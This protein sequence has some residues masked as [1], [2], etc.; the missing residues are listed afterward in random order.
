MKR[1]AMR[2][3]S[4]GES[5]LTRRRETEENRSPRSYVGALGVE[6]DEEIVG[7]L[8]VFVLFVHRGGVGG[9]SFGD[10]GA[11]ADADDQGAPAD[12]DQ[13]RCGGLEGHGVPAG[14]LI[15]CDLG[16]DNQ[17]GQGVGPA[18]VPCHSD[19]LELSEVVGIAQGVGGR[20][21]AAKAPT[22][23]D[24]DPGHVGE[25]FATSVHPVTGRLNSDRSSAART[26]RSTAP[27]R[28]L[29][30]A[31]RLLAPAA[32]RYC[33]TTVARPLPIRAGFRYGL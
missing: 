13:V 18:L 17:G 16:F 2:N 20:E 4:V 6:T 7:L 5:S 22:V 3:S 25:D 19:A 31:S 1:F 28:G 30:A 27:K 29:H 12:A 32:P 14:G 10:Q 23:M 8:G 21:A 33:V 9:K 15:D 24:G 26:A 11:P